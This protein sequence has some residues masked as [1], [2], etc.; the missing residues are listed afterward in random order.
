MRHFL[1][2]PKRGSVVLRIYAVEPR[3][4]VGCLRRKRRRPAL[5]Q[6][7]ERLR[8]LFVAVFHRNSDRM[9]HNVR[10]Y[11]V[12]SMRHSPRR[13]F[14][15]VYGTRRGRRRCRTRMRPVDG[16]A[17]VLHDAFVD[18]IRTLRARRHPRKCRRAERKTR[19]F[20]QTHDDRLRLLRRARTAKTRIVQSRKKCAVPLRKRFKIQK[21]LRT[22]EIIS[23]PAQK[24]KFLF[25]CRRRN[26]DFHSLAGA[27]GLN[28]AA[29]EGR[30]NTTPADA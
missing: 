30:R 10:R 20:L 24:C 7:F 11:A 22:D 15:M 25:A 18:A 13:R 23:L 17:H 16:Q 27:G 14:E 28:D 21:M 3:Q 2:R 8:L 12:A 6:R 5:S 9:E 4:C 19:R 29:G 1:S 26:A